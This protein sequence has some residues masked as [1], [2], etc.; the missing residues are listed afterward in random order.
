MFQT[1]QKGNQRM[2]REPENTHIQLKEDL[3]IRYQALFVVLLYFIKTIHNALI[4]N[5]L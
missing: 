1:C 5:G 2:V 3:D 4:G